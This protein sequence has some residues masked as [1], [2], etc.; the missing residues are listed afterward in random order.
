MCIIGRGSVSVVAMKIL[1]D[2]WFVLSLFPPQCT[3]IQVVFMSAV[4][5]REVYK[6]ILKAS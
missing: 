1:G 4:S 2:T 6:G 5:K 3:Y